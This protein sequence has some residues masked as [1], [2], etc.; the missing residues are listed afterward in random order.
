MSPERDDF[1]SRR[2]AFDPGRGVGEARRNQRRQAFRERIG[3]GQPQ[4]PIVF[5]V[6]HDLCVL[7]S[8]GRAE[9][10]VLRSE[11]FGKGVSGKATPISS[12]N[13]R[14]AAACGVSPGCRAPAGGVHAHSP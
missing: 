1:D 5:V 7:R 10:Y 8:L 13:S 11:A 9:S 3:Q 12:F 2:P 14:A 6:D 4:K